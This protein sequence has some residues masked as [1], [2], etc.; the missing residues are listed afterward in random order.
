M[1]PKRLSQPKWRIYQ[2]ALQRSARREKFKKR[3]AGIS[4]ILIVAMAGMAGFYFTVQWLSDHYGSADKAPIPQAV[5][6]AEPNEQMARQDLAALLNGKAQKQGIIDKQFYISKAGTRYEVTTSINKKL[7]SYIERLL[8]NSRTQQ[9]AVVVMNPFDGRILAMASRDK[10][11]P[12]GNLCL[13]ADFPAASL[14]KIVAAAAAME[15]AGYTPDKTIYYDGSRHTLYKNQLKQKKGRFSNKTKFRRA[16]A[17]SNNIVFGK[18]GIYDLGQTVIADYATRFKFNRPIPFE[19]PLETSSIEV[20]AEEF[21]LAEVASGFNKRTLISPIHAAMLAATVAN[22]GDMLTPWMVDSIRDGSDILRYRARKEQL[23]SPISNQTAAD[24][25]V[26]M[27]D[28]VRY[29]TSRK[30]FSK[31]RRQKMFK[32]FELGAKTG[33]I[34]DHR[35]RF[36]YDWITAYALPPDKH[37]GISLGII[38]VH[39]KLLGV[40]ATELARAV[41]DY[42]FKS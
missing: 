28:A 5:Q 34:N 27:G 23:G 3:L 8:K 30:A 15:T 39:G 35:D 18:L 12:N 6:T 17:A 38:V 11:S 22:Q 31:L 20:P 41:I 9:A 14:F 16:F 2:D 24:L 25:M 42:Y 36:K 1:N 7:Q 10:E 40:R 32:N 21:G 29:G 26:L 13:R 33:T 19:L 37:T 4:A